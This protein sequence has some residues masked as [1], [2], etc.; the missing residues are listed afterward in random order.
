[1]VFDFIDGAAGTETAASF[2]R[3][4]LVRLRLQPRVLT[5]TDRPT[6]STH[7]LGSDWRLPLGIAPMGLCDLAWPG[8]DR[9]LAAEAGGRG[10]A[11]CLSTAAS[12]PLEE[13]RRIAGERAWFQLYVSASA[14]EGLALADR[15]AVAGY[16]TLV[17][18]VDV[19][20]VARRPRD[21]RNGFG[22]PFR[23][24][25]GQALDLALHPRWTLATIAA[26]IPRPAN[27]PASGA[28][29]FDRNASRTGANWEFLDR[30]RARWRGMLIVKGVMAV[31]DARRIRN[32][33]A[34]AVWVSN[35]GGRQLDS[36]PSSIAVLP[37]IRAAVGRDYPLLVDGGIRCGE[38]IVKALACGANI[39]M[40]GRPFLFAIAA[41]GAGGLCAFLDM[42][43]E[44]IAITLAQIGR[45]SVSDIDAEVLAERAPA[46]S[47]LDL[48]PPQAEVPNP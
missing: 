41:G 34:D 35:H 32:A 5:S 1:M 26:G 28:N 2:N 25:P 7:F 15:A 9:L 39:A 14:E 38:D 4:D 31:E 22:L 13:S 44:E 20:R 3:S 36:A 45:V 37:A 33:G 47:R 11:H 48:S 24:G 19:P 17:F 6:L 18:T 40:L 12:T 16:R 27:F 23:I 46:S 8:A 21:V 30:L 43:A 29:G 42:L 10:I